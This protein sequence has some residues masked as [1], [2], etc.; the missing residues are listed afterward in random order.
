MWSNPEYREPILILRLWR[1][2][3]RNPPFLGTC[4]RIPSSAVPCAKEGSQALSSLVF[5]C[6]LLLCLAGPCFSRLG[7]DTVEVWGSSPHGPTIATA[8]CFLY[9]LQS[10]SSGRFYVGSTDDLDRRLSEHH[11]GHTASTRCRGPRK[12]VYTEP[13]ET[14]IQARLRELEIQKR[15]VGQANAR[16][17]RKRILQLSS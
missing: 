11:R 1:T 15:E 4:K 5:R 16:I 7:I 10:E 9:I 2:L 6:S 17:D 13:L 14:L 8:M 3:C 12:L